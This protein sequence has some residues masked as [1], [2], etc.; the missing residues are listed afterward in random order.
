MREHITE[1]CGLTLEYHGVTL[2]AEWSTELDDDM[3]NMRGIVM[4]KFIGCVMHTK[5]R[6]LAGMVNS[7]RYKYLIQL[8]FDDEGDM[9]YTSTTTLV[10]IDGNVVEAT[11]HTLRDATPEAPTPGPRLKLKF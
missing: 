5:I 7:G 3:L 8:R 9:Q 11:P 1:N 10:D 4:R 6:V 2:F